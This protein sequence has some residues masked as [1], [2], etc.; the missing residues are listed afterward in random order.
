MLFK[1][2]KNF[3]L[4]ILFKKFKKC[5]KFQ[6]K[7]FIYKISFKRLHLKLSFIKSHL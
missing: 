2:L 7:N 1:K 6:L 3:H 5:K 4:K